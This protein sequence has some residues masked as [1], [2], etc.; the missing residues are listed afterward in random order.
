[1]DPAPK[2]K[3]AKVSDLKRAIKRHEI[4]KTQLTSN[5][6]DAKKRAAEADTRASVAEANNIKITTESRKKIKTLENDNLASLAREQ[7]TKISSQ[8]KVDD[9]VM[10]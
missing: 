3:P 2:K 10:K 6:S 7:S 9:V 5:L 1:M 8:E 4:A